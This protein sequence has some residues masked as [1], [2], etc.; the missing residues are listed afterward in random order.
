MNEDGTINVVDVIVLVNLVL[1]NEIYNYIGDLNNDQ[2]L[3]IIDIVELINIILY[4]LQSL[5]TPMEAMKPL[6]FLPGIL[7]ISQ[8][9]IILLIH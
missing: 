9:I 6:I 4:T 1:E 8:K 3:N 7:K 5:K 2:I